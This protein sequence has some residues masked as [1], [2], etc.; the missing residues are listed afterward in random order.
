MIL[1]NSVLNVI[2]IFFL[3]ILKMYVK[4]WKKIMKIHMRFFWGCVKE[5]S[6]IAYVKLVDV[7]KPKKLR[8]LVFV[9]F[10]WSTWPFW[11]SGVGAYFWGLLKFGMI[12][13]WPDT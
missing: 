13:S 1:H 10:G 12:F 11:V 6:K 4:V 9:T 3:S 5:E 8:A 7:C 2:H